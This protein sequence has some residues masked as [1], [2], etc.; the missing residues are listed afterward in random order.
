M[1]RHNAAFAN[2]VCRFGEDKVLLDYAEEVVIPAFTR[3]RYVRSFGERTHYR[4]YNVKLVKLEDTRDEPVLALAGRFLKDTELTRH[5]IFDEQR[6]LVRD[7]QSLRSSPSVYFVLILN[8]HRLIYFPE[9]PY[10]PE[11][12]SFE[13][14]CSLFLRTAHR[15]YVDGLY[16][17]RRENDE[18]VTKKSLYEAHPLPTLDVIPLAGRD[19]IEQFMRRYEVLKRIDFRLVRPNDDIDAGEIL[20]QVRKF[21]QEL[22]SA[23]IGV[24]MA[25]RGG[26][27]METAVEAVASATK[28]GNQEVKLNG[29]DKDGNRLSGNN[30]K[31]Q[32]NAPLPDAPPED[33]TLRRRLYRMY[34]RMVDSGEIGAGERDGRR[35]KMRDLERRV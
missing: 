28:G 27:D 35:E 19:D 3:E 32:I 4:F 33:A 2:F 18:G 17:E 7:E 23:T 14:T 15:Q 31:F 20:S 29:V 25:N 6:G 12:K 24:S 10:A 8:N 21:G 22:N 30:Q 11:F 1:R 16:R 26:L 13:A 9:T 34:R 5:Q